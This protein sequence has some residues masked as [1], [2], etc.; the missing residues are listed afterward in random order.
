MLPDP[1]PSLYTYNNTNLFPN[2]TFALPLKFPREYSYYTDGSFKPPKQISANNWR[3]ETAAYGIYCPIKNI[4]ISKRLPGFQNILR[5]ELMAIYMV[6][7]L[8]TTTYTDEPIYI[9][10][11]SLNSLYL[12]NTQIQHPSKYTNHP[13]KTILTQIVTMLHSRTHPIAL[14]KVKA[15]TDI[16]GNE[17]VDAL[18]K[19][20]LIKPYSPP[21]ESHEHAHSTPYYLHKDEWI[22]MHYT[23]YKGPIH[24]FQRYLQKYTTDQHL[25]ELTRN[26][27]NIYKWTSDTNIDSTSSNA[28]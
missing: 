22:G 19:R 13:D 20:R 18:A 24:N 27:P 2:Y 23:P 28:F 5:A 12:I 14:H 9:F 4:Q 6:I 26:V 7:K 21:Q 10:T 16:T 17:T 15:H 25:I 3:P 1:P 11:D 8:S